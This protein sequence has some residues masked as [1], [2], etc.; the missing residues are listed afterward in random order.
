MR[1]DQAIAAGVILGVGMGGF[2][3]GFLF[4]MIL[5]W[6]HMLSNIIPPNTMGGVH[7]NM[8][9]DGLFYAFIW[10][11]TLVGIFMLWNAAKKLS[12]N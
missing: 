8:L 9:W 1:I 4:R 6:H 12:Q 11:V 10:L 3:D 5:R 2:V 7:T